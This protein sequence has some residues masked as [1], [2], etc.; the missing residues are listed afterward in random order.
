[1]ALAHGSA[2][3]GMAYHWVAPYVSEWHKKSEKFP[4]PFL[5]K[6]FSIFKNTHT[7]KNDE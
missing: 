6:I 5:L 4:I 1:M 7:F 3:V 2:C